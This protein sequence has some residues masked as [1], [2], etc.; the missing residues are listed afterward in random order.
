[1]PIKAGEFQSTT[2]SINRAA[3]VV[4]PQSPWFDW[5]AFSRRWAAC[6]SDDLYSVYL[7]EADESESPDQILRRNFAAIFEEQ[8]TSW[9]L[10]EDDW[11]LRRT[12]TLFQRWFSAR[13]SIW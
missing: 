10:N 3:I 4:R 2:R 12:F 13:W 1:M 7:V 6:R 5:A 8:L 11:P 9:H